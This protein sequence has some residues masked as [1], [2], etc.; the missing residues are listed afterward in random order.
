MQKQEIKER[1]ISNVLRGHG[2]IL[3]E[4]EVT[5]D[6]CLVNDL[7]FD[8]L[9]QIETIMFSEQ[10]FNISIPDEQAEKCNTI[11]DCVS[12]IYNYIN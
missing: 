12:L 4:E 8:S 9:D 1:F 6:T 3:P 2:L 10:E 5:G 7:G 11:N